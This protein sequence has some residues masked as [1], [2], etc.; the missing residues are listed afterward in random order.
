MMSLICGDKN[1]LIDTEN[2]LVVARSKWWVMKEMNEGDQKI[3]R[4]K[5]K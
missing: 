1:K 2:K 5:I 3:N 4:K